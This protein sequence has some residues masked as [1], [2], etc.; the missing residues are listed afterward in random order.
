[1]TIRTVVL[2]F[3]GTC[4]DVE[5]EAQGFLTSYKEDLARTLQRDDIDDAWAANEARV[6]A[7]PSRYGMVIG[8][9]MVAPAVD[10]YL[11]ATAISTLIEPD[12]DDVETERLFKENY[13]YTTTAFKPETKEAVEGLIRAD[14]HLYVV[15]NSDAGKV[16]SKLDELAP[17][18]RDAIRLH[19]NARKFLV[20]EPALHE[21]HARFAAVPAT[22]HVDGWARAIHPRRGHYFDALESIWQATS[23]SPHET[24]VIGDVFELDLVLPGALGC[25]V[26]LVPSTRTLD[27]ERRGV[28]ALGGSHAE[29]LRAVLDLL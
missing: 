20:A 18:G 4:T 19:G 10:L 15:T 6:L 3:D 28:A 27:Y 29:D 14:C 8:G 21:G 5:R 11:L 24:L 16:G 25:S 7:E 9:L 13:R 12:L 26:H 22:Q 2:D 23:T 1:M 17:T